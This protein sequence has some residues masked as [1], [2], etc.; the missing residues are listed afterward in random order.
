MQI[1]AMC[2]SGVVEALSKLLHCANVVPYG[3]FGIITTLSFRAVRPA[4]PHEKP[5]EAATSFQWVS[6][7]FRAWSS[8][9]IIFRSRVMG[10]SL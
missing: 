9:N 2:L 1:R 5:H 7:F 4:K 8:S 10:T 3:I 6:L